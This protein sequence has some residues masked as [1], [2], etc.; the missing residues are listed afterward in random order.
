MSRVKRGLTRSARHKKMLK[1]ATGY[2]G[3]ARTCYSV[4]LMRVHKALQYAYRD[5]KV[6]KR[7]FR[8]LWVVRINAAVRS[9][10]LKYSVFV[11]G[12]KLAG[13]ELD[14][15]VL[16]EMAVNYPTE[17]SGIVEKVKAAI[18]NNVQIPMSN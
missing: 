16:A 9:F 7:D 3:R 10:G 2:R 13:V 12:L 5:R 1:L 14:R 18:S 17:F 11:H 4:A 15:K 8:T 6:R